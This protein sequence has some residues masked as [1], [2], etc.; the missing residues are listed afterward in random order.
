M[1]DI[2]TTTE[3]ETPSSGFD[4]RLVGGKS[5]LSVSVRRQ[6]GSLDGN[7]LC[8]LAISDRREREPGQPESHARIVAQTHDEVSNQAIAF[9]SEHGGRIRNLTRFRY[10]LETSLR[11]VDV[12]IRKAEEEARRTPRETM[13][14]VS[15][16]QI[17]QMIEELPVEVTNHVER[18][19]LDTFKAAV[20]NVI[21]AAYDKGYR[22]GAGEAARQG[23]ADSFDYE[24][25]A[26]EFDL[27]G[28]E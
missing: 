21:G 14:S 24:H 16:D 23:Q 17:D 26:Y 3:G 1:T 9:V 22:D 25:A 18:M 27:A 20:R 5:T 2:T 8:D 28:I 10:D 12:A 19:M 4:V 7:V 13:L 11:F 15:V 6:G